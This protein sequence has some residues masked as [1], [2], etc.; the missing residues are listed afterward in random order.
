[1]ATVRRD[2][3]RLE[4]RSR[5]RLAPLRASIV[6][7]TLAWSAALADDTTRRT[8]L[9]NNLEAGHSA[10]STSGAKLAVDRFDR[11]GFVAL[12][13]IGTGVRLEGGG[14][15]PVLA[16]TTALGAALGGYQ[17]VRRWGVATLLAGPEL[18]FEVLAGLDGTQPLP[19]RKGLRLHGEIWARPTEATLA[20]ASVIVG[21]ARGEAWARLSWGLSL[22]GAYFGRRSSV[23]STGPAIASG[24]SG[25]TRPILRSAHPA[26]ASP[27]AASSRGRHRNLSVPARMSRWRSGIRCER[28]ISSDLNGPLQAD[29]PANRESASRPPRSPPGAWARTAR[30]FGRAWPCGDCPRVA[31]HSR[32]GSSSRG[33]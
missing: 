5:M 26:S 10:F 17:F 4:R 23:R 25:C 8:V 32:S 33:S 3:V 2:E 29:A 22:F 14:R 28:T 7:A 19:L 21:S 6:M 9:F 1:M 18:S 16:R 15:L 20:T 30:G 24:V 11:D 12:V 27:R 13:S 31:R